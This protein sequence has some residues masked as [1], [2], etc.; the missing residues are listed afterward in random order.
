MLCPHKNVCARRICKLV[1]RC[2]LMEDPIEKEM[3]RRKATIADVFSLLVT[4]GHLYS[5]SIGV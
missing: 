3:K 2:L 1:E 4:F 5:P